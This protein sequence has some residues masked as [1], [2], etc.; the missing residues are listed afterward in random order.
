MAEHLNGAWSRL[1]DIAN[2]RKIPLRD[3][4]LWWK[5]QDTARISARNS[6]LKEWSIAGMSKLQISREIGMSYGQVKRA[7]ATAK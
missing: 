5:Y 7:I 2:R 4:T 1:I 3:I 6:A